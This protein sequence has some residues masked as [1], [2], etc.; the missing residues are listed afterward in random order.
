M[1]EID[2]TRLP[3]AVFASCLCKARRS[4]PRRRYPFCEATGG[5][6]DTGWWCPLANA[7]CTQENCP[8]L[9]V[10]DV[11]NS[12]ADLNDDDNQPLPVP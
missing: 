11:G 12:V 1:L 10:W 7:P 9:V 4:Q 6:D 8:A 2:L 5:H 3:W